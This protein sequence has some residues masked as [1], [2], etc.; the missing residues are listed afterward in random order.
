MVRYQCFDNIC[1]CITEAVSF[2]TKA[3]STHVQEIFN[4]FL[5]TLKAGL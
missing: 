2:D 4:L 5:L 1:T 3:H